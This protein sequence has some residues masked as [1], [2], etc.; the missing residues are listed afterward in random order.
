MSDLNSSRELSLS[1]RDQL[2]LVEGA[3]DTDPVT[4][5]THGFYKYP[6]RFSPAF[7]RSVIETF[8]EPGRKK[9]GRKIPIGR[10]VW[11]SLY[12][13]EGNDPVSHVGAGAG[14]KFPPFATVPLSSDAGVDQPLDKGTAVVTAEPPLTIA[15]AK[16]RLAMTI[17]VDPANIKITIDA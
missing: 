15:E 16:R 2:A 3:R 9:A 7:V 4:G 5:L 6:A 17:G 13:P 11:V 14:L 10:G 8:T 12:I 1:D